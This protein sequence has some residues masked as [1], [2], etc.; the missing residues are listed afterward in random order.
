MGGRPDL[1]RRCRVRGPPVV[2]SAPAEL[3]RSAEHN[4]QAGA[5]CS[6][7]IHGDKR[8]SAGTKFRFPEIN[9]DGIFGKSSCAS[10]C[11]DTGSGFPTDG[12]PK[13][14]VLRSNQLRRRNG[15]H[16]RPLA[17]ADARLHGCSATEWR[18]YRGRHR[19]AGRNR[20]RN[21]S[22]GVRVSTW[23]NRI[24]VQECCLHSSFLVPWREG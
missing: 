17:I 3:V 21:S 10:S 16:S 12:I 20:S 5:C 15:Y 4:N 23:R 1:R 18:I 24:C 8:K 6:E 22:S 7:G 14:Y 13:P 2:C 11:G 19:R 9:I